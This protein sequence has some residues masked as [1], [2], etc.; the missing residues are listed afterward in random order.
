MSRASGLA[1]VPIRRDSNENPSLY[2][3]VLALSAWRLWLRL[4]WLDVVQRYRRSI[5][6]P[7]WVTI[8][9]GVTIA[10]IGI[11]FGNLFGTRPVEYLPHLASG[12]ILW[13]FFSSLVMEG[14]NVFVSSENLINQTAMPFGF[15]VFRSVARNII[16]FLHHLV[17]FIVVAL[18]FGVGSVGTFL[19]AIPGLALIVLTGCALGFGLGIIAARFRDVVLIVQ[20]LMQLLMYLT[21]VFWQR[22]NLSE[23][24]VFIADYNPMYHYLEI[25][26]GPM[27]GNPASAINWLVTGSLTL[28]LCGVGFFLYHRYRRSVA[29][30]L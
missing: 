15:H 30:W 4:A 20:N 17:V 25:V 6:G 24:L 26:R 8:T 10:G 11:V 7:L 9:M 22:E 1:P 12:I 3:L 19:T 13:T 14:A 21:P 5:L 2:E 16:I 18:I 23:R 29:F 28:F 27:L